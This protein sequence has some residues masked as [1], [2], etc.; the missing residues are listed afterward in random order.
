MNEVRILLSAQRAMLF[1]IC[2]KFRMISLEVN[3]DNVLKVL[4]IISEVLTDEEK[5]LAYSLSGEIEG[6]YPELV[7]SD[8]SFSLD[9]RDIDLLPRLKI[10]VFSLYK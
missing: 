10:L 7:S 8:V 4:I 9:T 5:D 2:P 3:A 1:N 6:D